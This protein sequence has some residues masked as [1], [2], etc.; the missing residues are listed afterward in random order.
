MKLMM[1][2]KLIYSFEEMEAAGIVNDFP[3]I[4]ICG[5]CDYADSQKNKAR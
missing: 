3:Y 1:R 5:S 4:A 2:E